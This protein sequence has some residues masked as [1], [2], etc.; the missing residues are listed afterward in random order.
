MWWIAARVCE[1]IRLV[2][3]FALGL[4][5]LAQTENKKKSGVFRDL[6][7]LKTPFFLVIA[8]WLFNYFFVFY[9]RFRDSTVKRFIPVLEKRSVL[10]ASG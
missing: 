10:Y 8:L 4:S 2:D 9:V 5:H 7:L 1:R 6:F 3:A